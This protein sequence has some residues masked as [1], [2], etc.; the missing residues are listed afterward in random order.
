MATTVI[1]NYSRATRPNRYKIGY[2]TGTTY[3]TD[4]QVTGCPVFIGSDGASVANRIVPFSGVTHEPSFICVSS[5]STAQT[6][7]GGYAELAHYDGLEITTNNITTNSTPTVGSRVYL[8]NANTWDNADTNTSNCVAGM[9]VT[10]MPGYDSTY[11]SLVL[12]WDRL[13]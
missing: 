11:A 8:V 13:S 10:T 3:Y 12:N 7:S 6:F 2:S 4:A 1:H 5:S 9:C